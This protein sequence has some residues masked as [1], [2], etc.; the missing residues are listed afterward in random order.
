M[1]REKITSVNERLGTTDRMVVTRAQI[2][3]L[4][5]QYEITRASQAF[6]ELKTESQRK[7]EEEY[8]KLKEAEE[9]LD[10]LGEKENVNA[11]IGELD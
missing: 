2:T 1:L 7:F 6:E 4:I 3:S 11:M 10:R 8:R 9:M 5:K